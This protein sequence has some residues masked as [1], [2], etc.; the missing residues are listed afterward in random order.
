S[1]SRQYHRCAK[2]RVP[3]VG[4]NPLGPF[5]PVLETV[6]AR[7]TPFV[8]QYTIT[9]Y[10][11]ALEAAVTAPETAIGHLHDLA[12]DFGP[13][14]AVWRYDPVIDTDLTPLPWHE[15][16]FGWLA[17]ALAGT[18]DEVVV[19]FAHIY[20]KTKANTDAAARRH[21]FAW[22]DPAEDEK[23]ATIVGLARIAARHGMTLSVCAQ[24]HLLAHLPTGPAADSAGAARCVDAVRLSAIGGHPIAARE[25]GNRRGCACAESRDI[26][27]YDSCPHG[28]VYCYAVRHRD[29]ACEAHK[30]HDPAGEFLLQSDNLRWSGTA[31]QSDLFETAG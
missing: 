6:G 1:R 24:P 28:C 26:G 11:R 27:A 15:E 21:G 31:P 22:R 8:V 16:N 2:P 5:R 7:D 20:K 18:V 4:I 10:P 29:R 17:G 13:G 14:R 3:N 30:A 23:R 12:R 25:K 9:G 19:S